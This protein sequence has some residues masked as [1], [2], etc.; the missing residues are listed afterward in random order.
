MLDTCD[1]FIG[2]LSNFVLCFSFYD[3]Y[4]VIK[5]PLLSFSYKCPLNF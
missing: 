2:T 1:C 3:N 5:F 4:K